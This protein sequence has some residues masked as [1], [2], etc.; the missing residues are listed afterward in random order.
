MDPETS[1]S[2]TKTMFSIGYQI[3]Q[4]RVFDDFRPVNKFTPQEAM[5]S[6]VGLEIE[7]QG[8]GGNVDGGL[9]LEWSSMKVDHPETFNMNHKLPRESGA[10]LILEF[11]VKPDAKDEDVEHLS[12]KFLS[13]LKAHFEALTTRIECNPNSNYSDT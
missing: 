7:I 5:K 11:M 4:R 8:S 12:H 1:L 3:R 10:S 9:S 6:T 2:V 13:F